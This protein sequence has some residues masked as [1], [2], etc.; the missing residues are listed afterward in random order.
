MEEHTLLYLRWITNKD[1]LESAGNS[2]QC[3]VAAWTGGEIGGEWIHVYV[4][5]S[6]FAFFFSQ[7]RFLGIRRG[8]EFQSS[9]LV[10]PKQWAFHVAFSSVLALPTK[11]LN[12]T[13]EMPCAS[14]PTMP[15]RPDETG[16]TA[17]IPPKKSANIPRAVPQPATRPQQV[18]PDESPAQLSLTARFQVGAAIAYQHL[19]LSREA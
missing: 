11:H 12:L 10:L 3:Y 14:S 18:S 2:A 19:E 4:W 6:P 5:L 15:V 16:L 8:A 1:L 7:K 9:W 13:P 17:L